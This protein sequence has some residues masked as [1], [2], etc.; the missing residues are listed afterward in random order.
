M[1]HKRRTMIAAIVLGTLAVVLYV[2]LVPDRPEPLTR[3]PTT[4]Q[5]TESQSQPAQ[6]PLVHEFVRW[7]ESQFVNRMRRV[8]RFS[9]D[10]QDLVKEMGPEKT[11]DRYVALRQVTLDYV[12]QHPN[13]R[14][15]PDA[16]LEQ[17][18]R[19]QFEHI[20]SSARS[21]RRWIDYDSPKLK[22]AA[23]EPLKQT[24]LAWIP[25]YQKLLAVPASPG[26]TVPE[27]IRACVSKD[28]YV[29]TMQRV[30]RAKAAWHAAVKQGIVW[31][32][33]WVSWA[34]NMADNVGKQDIA[35]CWATV[36][37]I[38]DS[39]NEPNKAA[40]ARTPLARSRPQ[41]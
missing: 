10:V 40:P 12:L 20:V 23:I 14:D 27:R 5:R 8:G 11:L 16:D 2:V 36:N 21:S 41:P 9:T 17:L 25:F 37:D 33:S 38:Y 22:Q 34:T 1:R 29:Q 4:T 30:T 39:P 24:A 3:S 35:G 7:Y 28:E 31:Y 6:P 18:A 13:C 26:A 32:A 15:I 19:K